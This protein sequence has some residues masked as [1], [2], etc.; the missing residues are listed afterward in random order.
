MESAMT[1][2][3]YNDHRKPAGGLRDLLG[4]IGHTVSIYHASFAVALAWSNGCRA[5]P[6]DLEKNG[7]TRELE[8]RVIESTR[9]QYT[10]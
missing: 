8:D 2:L 4:R 6:A 7:F 1:T 9:A 5:N 10:P 3:T